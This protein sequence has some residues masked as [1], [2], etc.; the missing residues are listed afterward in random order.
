MH[1]QSKGQ[2][3]TY[4]RQRSRYPC[5][6]EFFFYVCVQALDFSLLYTDICTHMHT[7]YCMCPYTQT[8]QQIQNLSLIILHEKHV[9]INHNRLSLHIHNNTLSNNIFANLVGV[10]KILHSSFHLPQE[11]TFQ[12]SSAQVPCLLY[13]LFRSDEMI[14]VV[15]YSRFVSETF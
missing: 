6:H 10:I 13:R 1:K 2:I 4:H 7:Q 9:T 14:M 12:H 8:H 5:N 3:K 11:N 15:R